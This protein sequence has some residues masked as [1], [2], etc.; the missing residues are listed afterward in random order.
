MCDLKK[1]DVYPNW[2]EEAQDRSTWRGWFNAAAEDVN[3]ELEAEEQSKK[4]ELK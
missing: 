2:R 1:C 3:E 4:D